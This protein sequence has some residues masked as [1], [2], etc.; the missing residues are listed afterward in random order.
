MNRRTQSFLVRYGVTIASVA[1]A[2]AADLS[3]PESDHVAGVL[4]LAA[5][6]FSAWYGGLGPG[7]V[8]TVLSGLALDYFFITEYYALRFGTTTWVAVSVYL[9]VAVLI[10]SLTEAQSR[11]NRALQEQD[12]RKGEFMAVLG[13][14]LRN[15]LGPVSN[16]VALLRLRGVVD[17][18]NEQA[19]S[20]VER[21]IRNMTQLTND[22]LDAARIS[23]GKIHLSLEPI[24]LGALAVQAAEA[25]KPFCE[26][27]GQHLQVALSPGPLPL[28][29]D[30]TR[31]EQVLINLL[32]NAA[33]YTDPGGR[34]WLTVERRGAELVVR[35]RDNG[36]GLASEHLSHVFD[37]FA[38]AQSGSQG[39]LGIGLS[40]VRAL[41]ELHG[42]S[43]AAYSDGPGRGSEFVVKLPVGPGKADAAVGD[44]GQVVAA[45]DTPT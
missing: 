18:A 15:F 33:K 22:L 35:V 36:K 3:L 19:L 37:L 27:R 32:T 30:R 40:L 23:Q 25:V 1:V 6:A 8:A 9:C 7:L 42:G 44:L 38:Q 10:N 41:V 31:L 21:Q 11:L 2:L 45:R 4:L 14:E 39:G 26:S 43:V 29:G 5:V 34:I 28:K 12:R 17:D 13:H 20:I 24:D 16:A